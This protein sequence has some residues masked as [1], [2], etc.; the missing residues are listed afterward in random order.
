LGLRRLQ[1]RF[2]LDDDGNDRP[3]RLLA[4]HRDLGL[5]VWSSQ[6]RAQEYVA[7]YDQDKEYCYKGRGPLEDRTTGL[8]SQRAPATGLLRDEV[9]FAN[10]KGP[11]E[12]NGRHLVQQFS[13][14]LEGA[15]FFAATRAGMQVRLDATSFPGI[16]LPVYVGR[17][18]IEN[19]VVSLRQAFLSS[20]HHCLLPA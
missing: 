20:T 14:P 10:D 3:W 4:Q 16:K 15:Q 9:S 5:G 2:A 13:C 6:S 19:I 17:E 11:R 12:R 18:A 8:G 1:D 7:S